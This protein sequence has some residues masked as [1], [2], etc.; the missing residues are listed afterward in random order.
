MTADA[1]AQAALSTEPVAAGEAPATPVNLHAESSSLATVSSDR[2]NSGFVPGDRKLKVLYLFAVKERRCDMRSHFQRLCRDRDWTLQMVEVDLE[3]GEALH[4]LAAPVIQDQWIAKIRFFDITVVVPD[5][6]SFSRAHLNPGGPPPSRSARYPLGFPWLLPK[7]RAVAERRNSLIAFTWRALT[8]VESLRRTQV[9]TALLVHPEDM[10]RITRGGPADVPASIWRWREFNGLIAAGWWSGAVLQCHWGAPTAKPTR[11]AMPNGA[12]EEEGPRALPE[13]CT[14]WFYTGP[15]VMCSHRHGVSLVGKVPAKDLFRTRAAAALPEKMCALLAEKLLQSLDMEESRLRPLSLLPAGGV[16]LKQAGAKQAKTV[17][18]KSRLEVLQREESCK[19]SA[20]SVLEDVTL[21]IAAARGDPVEGEDFIKKGW[22]GTGPPMRTLKGANRPGRLTQ[23]GGGMC[24]P[25]RWPPER[26]VLPPRGALVQAI[27]D[28]W[29][30]KH[31]GAEGVD[32]LAYSYLAG[33]FLTDPLVDDIDELR[34]EVMALLTASGLA[35]PE[36]EVTRCQGQIDFGFILV[37]GQFLGDPDWESMLPYCTTG[38]RLGVGV[39]L[40]RTPAVWPPKKK[41]PL[42][43]FCEEEALPLNENYPSAKLHKEVLVREVAKLVA[44]GWMLE[45]TLK[46]AKAQLGEDITVAAL[47]LLEEK[48]GQFRLLHDGSNLVQVN[49]RIHVRD[50]EQY[51]TAADVQAGIHHGDLVQPVLG[52]SSDVEKA[53]K[54]IPMDKRDWKYMACSTE[55]MPPDKDDWVIHIN[56]QG[57]YGFS[58]ASWNWAVVASLLQR[59]AYY[60]CGLAYIFRFADDYLIVASSGAKRRCT[61]QIARFMALF[62]M[63]RVP[64]KWAK[65]KGGFRTDFVGYLFVWDKL[66]GGLTDRRASWL[67]AW[68]ERIADAGSAETRD[69]RG[70]LGRLSFSAAILRYLLPS[71]GPLYAWVAILVPGAVWPIPAA[72]VILLRWIAGKLKQSTLVGLKF[73]LV[74]CGRTLFKADAKAEGDIVVVGGFEN[75]LPGQTLLQCRWFSFAL[76]VDNAPWAFVKH[77]EAFRAITALE[78]FATLLCLML[79]APSAGLGANFV[80]ELPC[81]TDNQGN[82]ALVVKCMT[83]KFP[84][85]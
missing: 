28:A 59:L 84:L 51:P 37:L 48:P 46:E 20:Q 77:G 61:L 34:D 57:T 58:S 71:L 36:G 62:A 32:K 43:S 29:L 69:L 1:S 63:L 35:R 64:N 76:T 8:E 3:K 5:G 54:Q 38:A 33:K 83:T 31:F 11:L 66:L 9:I 80:L 23:D 55:P 70:G 21:S 50:G 15:A 79:F 72:L 14:E 75:P 74:Q 26:R 2:P 16:A 40:P 4:D 27:V 56:T 45:M 10:G 68:A 22:W 39:E 60:V 65:T 30:L 73:P 41:W 52:L 13:F 82:E 81:I 49:N 6:S 53:H 12:L 44:R 19:A 7:E 78:L 85:Y 47:A 42:P 18:L 25:G 24:C 17:E 67:A